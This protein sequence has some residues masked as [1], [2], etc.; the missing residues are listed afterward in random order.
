M[1]RPET[2]TNPIVQL[3]STADPFVDQIEAL[4]HILELEQRRPITSNEA[5]EIGEDLLAFYEALATPESATRSVKLLE[6]D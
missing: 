5:R 6:A 4:R 3:E 2:L 1:T